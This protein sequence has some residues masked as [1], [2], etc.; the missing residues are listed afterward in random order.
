M[1]KT[2]M[3]KKGGIAVFALFLILSTNIPTAHAG[4][5][6]FLR[7]DKGAAAT[8]NATDG[9][10]E[11]SQV[12]ACNA[13]IYARVVFSR[14][15]NANFGVRNWGLGD[16]GRK[17]FV[18]G[19]SDS[20]KYLSGAWF[21]LYDG[22][23]YVIDRDIA[24]YEDVKGLAVQRGEGWVR[25]VLHGSWSEP[26]NEPLANRERA[27]GFIS[28]STDMKG[29]SAMIKP[30]SVVNDDENDIEPTGT[31]ASS[32]NTNNPQNDKMFIRNNQS[33]FK[34]VVTT[35][36]DGYYTYYQNVRPDC[37]K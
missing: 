32:N 16:L 18:G 27:E 11:T 30:L 9:R 25:L 19:S 8:I 1:K 28:F 31:Y 34:F 7:R 29:T 17:I 2:N 23:N 35:N 20:D 33:Y 21:K 14:N 4:F 6:S 15:P 36:D 22:Q 37:K 3:F 12:E 10:I 5:F 24:G 13:P 26:D